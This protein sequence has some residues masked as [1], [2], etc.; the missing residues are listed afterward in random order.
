MAGR[1]PNFTFIR[2]GIFS[3]R[4]RFLGN[5]LAQVLGVSRR[6]ARRG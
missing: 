2:Q 4:A 1:E 5:C 3:K 6:Q